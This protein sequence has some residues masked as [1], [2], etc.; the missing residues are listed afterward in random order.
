MVKEN[1]EEEILELKQHPGKNMVIF[2][3]ADITSAFIQ[4]GLIDEYRIMVNPVILGAGNPLFKDI[5]KR[6]NLKLLDTQ[7]FNCG[8]VLLIYQ[9]D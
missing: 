3:G 6:L 9:P 7:P 2:G 4:L 1:I 8:N 5:K